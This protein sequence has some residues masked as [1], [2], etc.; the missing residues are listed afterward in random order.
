MAKHTLTGV[1]AAERNYTVSAVSADSP[2]S[3]ALSSLSPQPDRKQHAAI[4]IAYFIVH[5]LRNVSR[6]GGS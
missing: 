2:V 3:A 6:D 5:L 4:A 1:P